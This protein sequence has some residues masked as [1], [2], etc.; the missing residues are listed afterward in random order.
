MLNLI[1]LIPMLPLAG[2]AIVGLVGLITLRKTGE[3]LNKKLVSLI[4]LSSV[5]LAFL[6]SAGAVYQ[7]FWVE[8]KEVFTVDLFTWLQGG[9]LRLSDGSLAPF[10]ITWGF[11]LD[12]LSAVMILVVTGVGFLI[13]V[14]STGY[15]WD[16]S[17][18]YRFFCYLNLFMFAM[19]MLVLAN[20]FVL[21]FVGWEGVGLC[22][23]LLIGFYFDKKSAGDAAKKAFVV[24][25]IGDAGFIL[26]MMLIFVHFGSLRYEEVFSAAAKLPVETGFG[27]LSLATL[28]LFVGATG[29]SAQVPLYVWLPDAMEG[30]TPVSALIHAATM[31][32]AGVYMVARCN[33][34]FSRAP[35]T[36]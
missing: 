12:P 17:G 3:K 26:G 25:R 7:L 14:Y 30:P 21:M 1:W 31:V 36:M 10:T 2:S 18:Y 8:H 5:G 20:N 19:L 27:F 29:K 16:D 4:A 6:L 33:S 32:T 23:Y 28:C 22:S 9:S 24:N 35:D 15:V 13:H 34:L 11:Q